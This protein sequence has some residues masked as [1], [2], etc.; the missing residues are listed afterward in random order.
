MIDR[1]ATGHTLRYGDLPGCVFND[2]GC[3]F[4]MYPHPGCVFDVYGTM[5]CSG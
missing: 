3:M 4:D 5:V 2:P 1:G